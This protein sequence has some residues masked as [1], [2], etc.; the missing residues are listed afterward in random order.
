MSYAMNECLR[1]IAIGL[2]ALW[3]WHRDKA[4]EWVILFVYPRDLARCNGFGSR[5]GREAGVTL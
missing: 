2:G 4:E 5:I 1:K 3:F